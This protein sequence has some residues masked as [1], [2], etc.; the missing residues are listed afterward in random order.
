MKYTK[1]KTTDQLCSLVQILGKIFIEKRKIVILKS[2]FGKG[3]FDMIGVIFCP[4][5][6][7]KLRELVVDI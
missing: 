2:L 3:K 7:P 5:F 1:K 4:N 6:Y